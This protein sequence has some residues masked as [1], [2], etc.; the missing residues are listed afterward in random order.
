MFLIDSRLRDGKRIGSVSVRDSAP[1]SLI[2]MMVGRE[3]SDLYPRKQQIKREV[4]FE[5]KDMRLPY[6]NSP[7]SFSLKRGEVLGFSGLVGAGRSELM[8]AIFGLDPKY[9]GTVILEG[10]TLQIRSPRGAIKAGI[11]FVP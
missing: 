6:F 9:S 5:I 7:I 10:K 8:R 4:V 3:I 1:Q 11:G 2:K